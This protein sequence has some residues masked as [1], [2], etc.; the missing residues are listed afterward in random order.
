MNKQFDKDR[1]EVVQSAA[2]ENITPLIITGVH[3]NDSKKAAV[4]GENYP[5]ILYCTAGVH[6]LD[7]I[8]CNQITISGLR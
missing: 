8:T 6:P 1:E 5:G 4:Y 2:Q 7:A 3:L